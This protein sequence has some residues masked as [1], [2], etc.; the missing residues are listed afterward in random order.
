VYSLEVHAD[1]VMLTKCCWEWWMCC[2]DLLP[3]SRLLLHR[4][5]LEVSWTELDLHS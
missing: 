2:R 3:T 4:R 5:T 1:L